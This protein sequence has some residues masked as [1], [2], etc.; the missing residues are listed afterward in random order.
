MAPP[1]YHATRERPRAAH[2][3]A[4]H[5]I[6]DPDQVDHPA[7][8][9]LGRAAAWVARLEE[10]VEALEDLVADLADGAEAAPLEDAGATPAEEDPLEVALSV[11]RAA[12]EEADRALEER[13]VAW[14]GEDPEHWP[15]FRLAVLD[16]W[17]VEPGRWRD[18]APRWVRIL[19]TDAV[20][21][22]FHQDPYGRR[23]VLDL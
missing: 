22:H 8:R 14:L 1:C 23:R 2:G 7:L 5:P 12:Y 17:Q 20:L 11:V 9:E 18:G 15:I 21:A 3:D 10:A 13:L 6:T 19:A 16:P 4:M